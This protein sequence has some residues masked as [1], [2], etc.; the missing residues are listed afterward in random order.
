VGGGGVEQGVFVSVWRNA[1]G[2]TSE[3]K[4]ERERCDPS[5]SESRERF[6]VE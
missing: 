5:P 6:I 3:E 2:S 1:F 4:R